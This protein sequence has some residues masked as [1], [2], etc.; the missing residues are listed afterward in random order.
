MEPEFIGC[1]IKQLPDDKQAEGAALAT[2]YN[3]A[4]RVSPGRFISVV[5]SLFDVFGPAKECQLPTPDRLSVMN[6]KYWGAGGVKLTVGFP[7]DSTPADL[8]ARILSHMNAWSSFCNV[9]F[10][11]TNTDP[12]V[13]ISRGGD[14]YWSY[15]GSDVLLIPRNQPTMNLQGF[16]MNTPE[17]EFVRV[18]RHET[19]HTLGFPHEHMRG[20]LVSRLDRAKT[21]AYF[22][23][24]QGWSPQT[25][26]QQVLTPLSE[27]SIRGTPNADQD[28]I[29]CY[30]LSGQITID[31]QPIRGGANIDSLD[32]QFAAKLYPLPVAPPPPPPPPPPAG[33][34]M[35]VGISLRFTPAPQTV[36]VGGQGSVA[37]T[38]KRVS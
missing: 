16:T 17:S 3:P 27:A 35:N 8:Q 1:T 7:F 25:T 4:N 32:A 14:G 26:Q 6:T 37:G 12:Q 10:V 34:D 30:Q 15:L 5:T 36:P 18:V 23:A 28:S 24:T 11:L 9:K 22:Q 2:N 38:F 33:E 31:G 13:R 19:G 20:E 21:I 29:M